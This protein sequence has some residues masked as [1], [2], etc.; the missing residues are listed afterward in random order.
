MKLLVPQAAAEQLLALPPQEA[1]A[2]LDALPLEQ[3]RELVLALPAGRKRQDLVLLSSNPAELV[4]ALPPEDFLLTVKAIGEVDALELLELSSDEQALYLADLELWTQEGLDLPRLALLNEL[5]FRCSPQRLGRWLESLDFELL[6]LMFERTLVA[7][8]RDRLDELPDALAARVISP[9]NYHVMVVKLGADLD[10]VKQLVEYL[11]REHNQRFQALWG[12]LGTVPPAE[13]E[14]QALRWRAGRLA[15]RGWPDDEEARQIFATRSPASLAP[16]TLPSGWDNPPR[17][18]MP[19]GAAGDNLLQQGMAS[20]VD[21]APVVAQLAN[22]VNRVLV[23]EGWPPADPDYLQRAASRVHGH[24]E[25]GLRLLEAGD[26]AEAARLL[27]SIPLLHLLQAARHQ[28]ELL[29][30]RARRLSQ[31]AGPDRLRLL[32]PPLADILA[33]LSKRWPLHLPAENLEA[34]EFRTPTD[35][36]VSTR[37]LDLIEAYL[38]LSRAAGV[39]PAALPES[40]PAG[41]HPS[42]REGLTFSALLLSQFARQRLALAPAEMQPFPLSRW[43][44]LAATLPRTRAQLGEVLEGW[45]GDMLDR[46]LPGLPSLLKVLSGYLQELLSHPAGEL[47]PRFVAGMWFQQDA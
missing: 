18:V 45:S 17:A 7:V 15:D 20:L 4:Q 11:Y 41:C 31:Q 14:Q 37:Q 16:T 5:F 42:D 27:T 47:D 39:E 26:G 46:E 23:A 28:V 6:A 40:F 21:V 12:N 32:D 9:D 3:R 2:R 43:A 35:R 8:D 38:E 36:E 10:R 34:R 44:E 1:A 29:A 33:A 24:L 13:I 22:L 19:A 25:I 30:R